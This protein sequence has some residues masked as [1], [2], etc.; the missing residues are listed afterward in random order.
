MTSWNLS[1]VFLYFIFGSMNKLCM[2]QV[3]R[4]QKYH[5]V[6]LKRKNVFPKVIEVT[7]VILQS[8]DINRT[9]LYVNWFLWAEVDYMSSIRLPTF[10]TVGNLF[11]MFKGVLYGV[12]FLLFYGSARSATN[13]HEGKYFC[14][15]YILCIDYWLLVVECK[16]LYFT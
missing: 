2:Q 12:A 11:I 1:I 7:L 15:T 6:K 3:F 9:H 13:I 8:N 10:F 4:G 16:I 14:S 5:W